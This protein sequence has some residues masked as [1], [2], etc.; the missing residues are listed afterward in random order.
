MIYSIITMRMLIAIPVYDI[1]G[2]CAELARLTGREK[3]YSRQRINVLVKQKIKA[4]IR[5]GRQYLLTEA[6]LELLAE[7]LRPPGRPISVRTSKS[8]GS[9]WMRNQ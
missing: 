7:E 4:P 8:W 5:V 6:E 2:A 3:S 1:E 9:N